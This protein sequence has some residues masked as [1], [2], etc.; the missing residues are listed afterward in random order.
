[1]GKPDLSGSSLVNLTWLEVQLENSLM[2]REN[3]PGRNI[4]KC[5][6]PRSGEETRVPKKGRSLCYTEGM[7]GSL[8]RLCPLLPSLL[9]GQQSHQICSLRLS[10]CV[11]NTWGSDRFLICGYMELPLN[12]MQHCGEWSLG[13]EPEF[14]Y[15]TPVGLETSADVTEA[16]GY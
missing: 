8:V 16:V 15:C 13:L 7:K 2:K 1:M 5:K 11:R 12:E 10:C 4:S 6:D 3:F 9:S 14:N